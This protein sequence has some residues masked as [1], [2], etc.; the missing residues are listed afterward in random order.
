MPTVFYAL[1]NKRVEVEPQET[2]LRVSLRTAW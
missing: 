1:E 2:I